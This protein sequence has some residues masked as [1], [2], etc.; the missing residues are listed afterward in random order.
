MKSPWAR[1][2]RSFASLILNANHSVSFR[3]G[4]IR[5]LV[6]VSSDCDR[7]IDQSRL[8]AI[9]FNVFSR[10][11]AVNQTFPLAAAISVPLH[12]EIEP[13]CGVFFIFGR[14]SRDVHAS[15]GYSCIIA[16]LRLFS[17]SAEV[18]PIEPPFTSLSGFKSRTLMILFCFC[19]FIL[20]VPF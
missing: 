9:A 10:G 19:F 8:Y 15:C 7:R 16:D 18:A 12:C 6:D 11:P 3:F 4:S 5:R 13:H 1:A 2:F 14:L 20:S 17:A